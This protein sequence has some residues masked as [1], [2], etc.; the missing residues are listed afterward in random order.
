[1]EKFTI[2]SLKKRLSQKTKQDLIKEIT[3]LCQ[4]FPQ[5]KEYYQAQGSSIVEILQKYKGVIKKEFVD[6][7]TRGLPKSR[8]SVAR[9]AVN[10]FKKLTDEPELIADIMLTYVESVSWFNTE[11]GPDD[12]DYYA[13][14]EDMFETVL[15]LIEKHH[16]QDRFQIR[17]HNIVKNA[18]D[19]WGHQDSLRDRYDKVYGEF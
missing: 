15:D 13:R 1:M 6:G 8:F 12:E 3:A 2:T 14:P 16:L 19:A 7:G 11:Y 17:A 5:V 4:K 9:K 18:T 10:D